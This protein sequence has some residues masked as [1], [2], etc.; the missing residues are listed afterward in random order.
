MMMLGDPEPRR[1][2]GYAQ[3]LVL[4]GGPQP[5]GADEACGPDDQ[6]TTA[7]STRFSETSPTHVSTES[8]R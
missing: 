2:P 1:G 8:T 6:M 5:A 3:G 7:G 4:A